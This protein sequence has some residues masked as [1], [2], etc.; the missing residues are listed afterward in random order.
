MVNSIGLPNK[1]LEGFLLNDLPELVR[2]PVPLC[3]SVMAPE[4]RGVRH[5][6]RAGRA[7]RRGRGDRAQRL[8]PE[9]QVR[10][11]RRR[12]AGGDARPLRGAATADRQAA[13]R[14]ADSQLRRPGGG[15]AGRRRRGRRRGLADQHAAGDRARPGDPAPLARR[16]QRRALRAGGAADRARSGAPG[17]RRGLDPGDRDGRD[18]DRGG[19]ARLPG[20]G[21]DGDRGRDGELSRPGGGGED[22][23]RAGR[24]A[25]AS[26][27]W[28]GLPATRLRRPQ[29]EVEPNFAEKRPVAPCAWL[30]HGYTRGRRWPPPPST[31]HP[32]PFPRG[33]ASSGCGPSAGRTRSAPPAPS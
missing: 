2:L 24:G 18:R 15:R 17:R 1:G 6:G 12:A 30:R 9:R 7:P 28:N 14:Q 23:G 8:L 20:G 5:A 22:P 33:L 29:P 13:D 19:C 3:V 11:D 21:S 27:D 4:S 10:A 26:R 32:P 31:R 25:R 16:R